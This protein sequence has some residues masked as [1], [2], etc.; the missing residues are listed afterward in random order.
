MQPNTIT[1]AV[2]TENLGVTTNEVYTRFEEY[3]NRSVYIG[4]GHS[5]SSRNTLSFYRTNPKI[6]GNFRGTA[7]SAVKFSQDTSVPGVNDSPLTAPLIIEVS[8]SVP[9]GITPAKTL[10]ARQRALALLD[11]DDIMAHLHDLLMI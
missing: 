4:S 3:L 9:V 7:K 6:A 2:D 1:L 10:V 5:L 8:V 11:R